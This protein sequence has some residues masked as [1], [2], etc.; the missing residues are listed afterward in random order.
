MVD[1]FK[2]LKNMWNYACQ[3]SHEYSNL[4]IRKVCCGKIKTTAIYVVVIHAFSYLLYSVWKL[5]WQ[6][7]VIGA[8]KN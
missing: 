4:Q 6:T 3:S 7:S 1:A 2:D 8:P 5:E